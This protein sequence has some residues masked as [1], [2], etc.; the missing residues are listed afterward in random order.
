[1]TTINIGGLRIPLYITQ[2]NGLN[3]VKIYLNNTNN[4][5]YSYDGTPPYMEFYYIGTFSMN[6]GDMLIVNKSVNSSYLETGT[7]FRKNC[8]TS[9]TYY[10]SGEY[11][12]SYDYSGL[13]YGR[14][15]IVEDV[16]NYSIILYNQF[17]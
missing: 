8:D 1:M 4:E 6:V 16:T 10:G 14:Y 11:V 13:T 5:I 12:Q 17:D 7:G 9:S 2:A 15:I 3:W